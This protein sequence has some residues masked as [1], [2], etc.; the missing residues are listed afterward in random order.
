[1]KG[2]L[3]LAGAV[4]FFR[5]GLFLLLGFGGH[6]RHA[7]CN[8]GQPDPVSYTH[9][10]VDKRQV[11]DESRVIK[12]NLDQETLKRIDDEYELMAANADPDVIEPVSYTHLTASLSSPPMKA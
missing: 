4:R 3:L 7:A 2:Y 12:L 11:Y 1:M 6:A 8:A 10:D 5:G 9:L